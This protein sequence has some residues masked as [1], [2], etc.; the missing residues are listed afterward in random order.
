MKRFIITI[1][2]VSVFF[3]G[4]GVLIEKVGAKFKS[5]EKALELVRKARIAIGGENAITGV[6]S[7]LIVGK[8]T[9]TFSVDGFAR[10]E[11]GESEIALQLPDKLMRMMKL[12]K[13]DGNTVGEVQ[14][15]K[16]L[17]VVVVSGSKDKINV[18]VDANGTGGERQIIIKKDDGT[19]EELTGAEADKVVAM[20][21][22]DTGD[23][24]RRII[25]KK[26]DGTVEEINGTEAGKK[27]AIAKE[28]G[29]A[30]FPTTDGKAIIVRRADAG[31]NI[32]WVGD[33]KSV[34]FDR[35][36][37]GGLHGGMRQNEMLRLTLS[38]L[39][40]APQG[41]DVN[42]TF[43]GE[44]D[45]DGTACNI[46]IAEFGGTS[47][48]IFLSKSSNLPVMMN[49]TGH[50]MPQVMKFRTEARN[51]GEAPKDTMVFTRR[52]EGPDTAMADYSVKFSDYRS[53]GGVQLPYKWTQTVG[54][55]ADETF[56][57]TSYEINPA[58]IAEKFQNQRVM[59]RATKADKQ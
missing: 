4:L 25:I 54:G 51:S 11:E 58:N 2:C 48:K 27:I 29:T 37:N 41:M 10:S 15:T 39:M 8:T 44:S 22:G 34:V 13:H 59:V 20:D 31:E 30:E 46:V 16:Q 12:G 53:V 57:V 28:S 35:E 5:D 52:M 23:N 24:F 40:T 19:V 49:Y 56:G 47:F 26:P 32:N 43:G 14:M 42:Y 6:Q 33:G 7:M 36:T 21:G 55:N 9:K 18:T 17:D 45:L 3:V 1:L 38:L 50:Q